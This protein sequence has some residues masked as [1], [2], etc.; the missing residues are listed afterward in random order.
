VQFLLCYCIFLV[1]KLNCVII[2]G[3]GLWKLLG[4]MEMGSNI[5]CFFSDSTANCVAGNG[6]AVSESN[7]QKGDNASSKIREKQNSY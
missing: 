5:G 6:Q 3:T 1:S 2:S 4:A 7:G